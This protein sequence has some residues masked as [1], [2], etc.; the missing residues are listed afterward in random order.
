V[1]L[2]RTLLGDLGLQGFIKTT[3]GKGLHVV[4][5]IRPTLSW[6]EGKGF[7]RRIAELLAGTF[8]DRFIAV[9][10]KSQRKGKIFIDY[11]RN[12]EGSTAIGPYSLR[13][14][15]HAPVATPIA[16]DELDSDV[17]FHH[18][19]LESVQ[20]RLRKLKRDPWADFFTT[21]QTITKAMFKRVG[22]SG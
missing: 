3:G 17:R 12:A 19:N 10:S 8:P 6:E 1:G 7:T 21:T 9:M 15:A 13:A 4:L 14:R 11:L 22:Y 5:P 20:A 2:L 16:W 18:F